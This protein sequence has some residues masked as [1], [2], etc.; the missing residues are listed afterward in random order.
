MMEDHFTFG[1]TKSTGADSEFNFAAMYSPSNSVTGANPLD[2]GQTIELEM[3][4]YELEAS[5]AWKF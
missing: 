2:P 5:W 3:T 1:F 4:Q